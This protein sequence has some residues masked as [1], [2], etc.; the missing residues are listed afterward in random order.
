MKTL[1]R[2][3]NI[4]NVIEQR[5]KLQSTQRNLESQ[6]DMYIP[7]IRYLKGVTEIFNSWDSDKKDSFI[8]LIG[9]RTNYQDTLNFLQNL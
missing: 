1:V 3:N 5:L 8:K 9:G 4:A 2:R 6:F 7:S